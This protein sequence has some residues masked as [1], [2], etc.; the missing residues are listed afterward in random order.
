MLLEVTTV[1]YAFD[2]SI[3]FN[4][5]RYLKAFNTP[6]EA[7]KDFG[8]IYGSLAILDNREFRT[9]RGRG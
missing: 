6:V 2:Y 4:H 3:V 1:L 5:F 7:V 9:R 8:K